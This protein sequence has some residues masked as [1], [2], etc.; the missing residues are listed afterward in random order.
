MSLSIFLFFTANEIISILF[1]NQWASTVPLFK[2][3]ALTVWM[4]I[5]LSSSSSVRITSYNVCYTKLLRAEKDHSI[6]T[7]GVKPTKPETGYG[8]IEVA[9]N[10]YVGNAVEAKRFWEK[11]NLHRAKKYVEAGNYLLRVG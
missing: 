10:C 6:V 2:I 3:L 11:P 7:L 1:G 9:E 4:Q 8:Y 5:V